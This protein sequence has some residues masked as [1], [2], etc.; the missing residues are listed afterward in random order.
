MKS[1]LW[2][3]EQR[4]VRQAMTGFAIPGV[5]LRV[6]GPDGKEVPHDGTVPWAKSWPEATA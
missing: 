1:G 3:G 4:Y 5:E 2:E 6:V